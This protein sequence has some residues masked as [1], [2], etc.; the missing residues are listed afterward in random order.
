MNVWYFH[1]VQEVILFKRNLKDWE[2][3]FVQ[4]RSIWGHVE[5]KKTAPTH[6]NE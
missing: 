1:S 5:K 6:V 2:M 4:H 3:I